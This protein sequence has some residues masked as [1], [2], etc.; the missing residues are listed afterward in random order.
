MPLPSYCRIPRNAQSDP[1]FLY[2]LEVTEADFQL[3]KREQALHVDFAAFPQNVLELLDLCAAPKSSE[4]A[5]PKCASIF[6]DVSN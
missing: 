4:G 3:L 1:F 2:Q 5:A 6:D